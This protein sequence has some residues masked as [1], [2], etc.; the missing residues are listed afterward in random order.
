MSPSIFEPIPGWVDNFNGPVG[1]MLPV[2]IGISRVLLGGATCRLNFVP[3]DY[4]SCS[5]ISIIAQTAVHFEKN[6]FVEY[7]EVPIYN[8]GMCSNNCV[9]INDVMSFGLKYIAKYPV[10]N[11][12]WYPRIWI[13]SCVF[14]YKI[15]FALAQLLPGFFVDLLLRLT[16]QKMR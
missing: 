5:L 8:Y 15:F 4:V 1:I 11:M 3:V 14:L 16:K 13:T 2:A 9:D 7:P 10:E 12:L 6:K